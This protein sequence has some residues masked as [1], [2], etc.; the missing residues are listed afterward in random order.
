MAYEE[1]IQGFSIEAFQEGH[2]AAL[3]QVFDRF[4]A[5]IQY[6]NKSLLEGD[7]ISEEI[8]Q[9]T[10]LKLWN[11]RQNFSSLDKIKAFLYLAA[12]NACLDY[13]K[14]QQRKKRRIDLFTQ[15]QQEE[16]ESDADRA[17]IREEVL[18][19][20]AAA[21]E[22][23]PEQCR[24]VIRMAYLNGKNASEIAAAIGVTASTVRSQQSRGISLLRK[25]LTGRQFALF[26]SL[27]P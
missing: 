21:I 2:E 27:L 15:S 14:T 20:I 10:F 11:R 23:L 16:W 22:T 19:T 1:L 9:D 26:L 24:Q 18:R 12:K 7:P 8:T 5:S 17:I 3:Q 4:Y 25:K 13:I 6:M